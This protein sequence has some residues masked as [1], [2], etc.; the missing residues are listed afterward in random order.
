MKRYKLFLNFILMSGLLLVSCSSDDNPEEPKNEDAKISTFSFLHENNRSL[1][2]SYGLYIKDNKILGRLPYQA[3][4]EN[5]IASFTHDGTEVLVDN[6]KQI[7]G[8][9]VNDFSEALIYNVNN[10]KGKSSAY[11]VDV[12][13]FTGLPIVYINTNDGVPIDSKEEYRKG[14]V[15][16]DGGRTHTD[17]SALKMKI[18]GR[19]NSTWWVSDKKPYQRKLSDKAEFL[20]MPKDKKW[21]FL[22]EYSDKSLIRNKIAFELGYLSKLDWTPQ[23]VFA[24]VIVND[25][26]M[27]TYNITQK[28]EESDNR[29]N[30]GD[31]G[32]LLEI[33]N[34]SR[35]DDDD[36][37]FET[38]KFLINIKEP[39]LEYDSSEYNYIND[40][41]NEFENVLMS[42]D[43]DDP[44]TGYAKYI[45]IDSFIDWYLISEITKN[46][47]S[48]DFSSIYLNVI[49]GEKIKMGPL[50]DFDLAFGN[51]NY[52]ECEHSEGFWIKHHHWYSRLFEDPAFKDKVKERYTYYRNKQSLIIEKIDAYAKQL[53]WAQYE[54]NKKW[55]LFG[56]YVWPNPVY[57]DTHKEEV[58][59]LKNWYIK[60]MDWLEDAFS[61]L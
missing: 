8:K 46:Q 16:I 49:P 9:S 33:D 13:H 26:Y 56:R 12:T 45:D 24:E 41:M 44:E 61:K 20:G 50:W 40:F 28:V 15:S 55:D 47:D 34:P 19:G 58:E 22:A 59:H 48:R 21:I 18:R 36:V 35:L 2:K 60:R 11:E 29:V 52:S 27:G 3:D 57:F 25:E 43:F 42:D 54:N 39:K 51:V 5:L 32:Y 6:E 37:F 17:V 53:M 31:T 10:S 38:G 30:I 1:D 7:S 23:S 14:E 4:M